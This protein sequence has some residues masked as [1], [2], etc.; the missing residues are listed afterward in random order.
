[1]N[2]NATV[3]GVTELCL[4]VAT[5]SASYVFRKYGTLEDVTE[6]RLAVW[7]LCDISTR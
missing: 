5:E 4:S 1:M 7:S 2:S 6:H 3:R